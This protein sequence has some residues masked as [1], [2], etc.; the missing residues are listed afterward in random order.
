MKNLYKNKEIIE[1]LDLYLIYLEMKDLGIGSIDEHNIRV[2]E[3][4]SCM[5]TKLPNKVRYTLQPFFFNYTNDS[6]IST[7][8]E[9]HCAEFIKS[10][11]KNQNFLITCKFFEYPNRI[12]SVRIMIS[13]YTKI[14]DNER[15]QLDNDI[16]ENVYQIT[17]DD[18]DDLGF[19]DES[20]KLLNK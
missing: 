15:T 1:M 13:A 16:D 10:F 14:G 17:V 7:Y 8:I 12:V 2:S 5:K 9:E 6:I 3:W 11:G 18:Y 20:R 4:H 19:D